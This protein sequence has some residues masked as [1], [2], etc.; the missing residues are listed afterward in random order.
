MFGTGV[1]TTYGTPVTPDRWYEIVS[2]GI[3]RQ[4]NVLQSSGLRA[5]ARNLRRG[6]RRALT[7][8]WAGGPVELEVADRGMGR[9]FNHMLGGSPTI[10]QPDAGGAPTVYQHVYEMGSTA[11]KSLTIQKGLRDQAGTEVESFTYHGC[12][13]NTWEMS[14]AVGEILSLSLGVDC[15]DEDRTTA[16]AAH[17]YTSSGLFTFAGGSV[18]IDDVEVAKVMSASVQGDN[19][20]RTDAFFLGT[21]GLKGEPEPNDFP[22]V[23]GSLSVEFADPATFYD[24]FVGDTAAKFELVFTGATITGAHKYAVTVEVPEVHFTGSTPKVGGPGVV[25]HEVPFEG[26]YDGTQPGVRI[27]YVTTDSAA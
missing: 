22:S 16:L 8:R 14:V 21:G 23:S 15:E 1:E 3:E 5:G 9:L 20:L 19:A 25:N 17:S 6:S 18:E 12:K 24:L 26:A 2:E 11:G 10:T 27:T 4:H 13:L 7:H